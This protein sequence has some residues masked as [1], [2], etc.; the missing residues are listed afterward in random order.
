MT[1]HRLGID[2]MS[3]GNKG[4]GREVAAPPLA[5]TVQWPGCP[6]ALSTW[7]CHYHHNPML[8]RSPQAVPSPRLPSSCQQSL[9]SILLQEPGTH[10]GLP[11]YQGPFI[12]LD[13]LL[14][15]S[16]YAPLSGGG[17]VVSGQ[18]SSPGACCPQGY[19]GGLPS[20]LP[21][22][23]TDAQVTGA[24]SLLRDFVS[25]PALRGSQRPLS[26]FFPAC[27]S[28][29]SGLEP[30]AWSEAGPGNILS[31]DDNFL[32]F[33]FFLFFCASQPF[34]LGNWG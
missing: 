23:D 9:S 19:G 16:A 5:A 27:L 30:R 26:L 24:L 15:L 17:G 11:L 22:G 10:W 13:P 21:W 25:L 34:C 8:L 3:L 2:G 20:S 1:R 18:L 4:Q 14:F 32:I 7:M 12:G 28:P 29:S 31:P 6:P 33:N